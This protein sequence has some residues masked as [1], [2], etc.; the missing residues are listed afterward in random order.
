MSEAKPK[1]IEE[2]LLPSGQSPFGNW[3]RSLRDGKTRARLRVKL[4]RLKIG[5]LGDSKSVDEGVR[6]L[7]LD[8]GPG[9][10]IYFGQN[11][12]S[13]VLLLCGGTK[14][15]QRSDIALAHEYWRDYKRRSS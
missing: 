11:G 9:Y 15:T 4:D 13:L 14:R 10:R 12:E 3:L 6:E 5:N 2:Y 8:F 7:R 1:E